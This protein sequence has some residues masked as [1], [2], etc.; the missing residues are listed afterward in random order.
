MCGKHS[1]VRIKI[2]GK[3]VRVDSCLK[4]IILRLNELGYRTLACCCGHGVYP[5]TIIVWD[6]KSGRDNTVVDA[7]PYEF[8]T[9]VRI[10]R[11]KKF[12]KKDNNSHYYIPEVQELNKSGSQ[13][14]NKIVDKDRLPIFGENGLF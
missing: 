3:A 9:G 1:S 11:T 10:P 13:R 12:Y 5:P 6:W 14:K 2:Q 4:A 7:K 8:F